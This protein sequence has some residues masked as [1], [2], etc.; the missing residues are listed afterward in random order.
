MIFPKKPQ[1]LYAPM[2][3]TFGG[4]SAN[5]FRASSGETLMEGYPVVYGSDGTNSSSNSS[6]VYT[7]T[8][9]NYITHT[10]NNGLNRH[11]IDPVNGDLY[12]TKDSGYVYRVPY[13][14]SSSGFNTNGYNGNIIVRWHNSFKPSSIPWGGCNYSAFA[15]YDGDLYFASTD[16]TVIKKVTKPDFINTVSVTNYNTNVY[17]GCEEDGFNIGKYFYVNGYSGAMLWDITTQSVAMSVSNSNSSPTCFPVVSPRDNALGIYDGSTTTIKL[18]DYDNNNITYTDTNLNLGGHTS[19]QSY[20]AQYLMMYAK[21]PSATFSGTFSA[22]G[23]NANTHTIVGSK[24]SSSSWVYHQFSGPSGNNISNAGWGE[25]VYFPSTGAM[26]VVG[27]SNG[28]GG[29]GT[30]YEAN[31]TYNSV[32]SRSNAIGSNYMFLGNRG[33][34]SAFFSHKESTNTPI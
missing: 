15:V 34:A 26:K 33:P 24:Y 11:A 23:N 13:T 9:S 10:H 19:G 17:I 27:H 5:G 16:N 2:L 1:I 30:V 7:L 31:L 3:A 32:S 14:P 25:G 8:N 12:S 20:G 29:G 22:A 4:G 28:Q 21:T 6:M 18:M